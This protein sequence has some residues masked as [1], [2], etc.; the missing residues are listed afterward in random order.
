MKDEMFKFL[1]PAV[2]VD[3]VLFTIKDNDLKVAL[4]KRDDEPYF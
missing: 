1:K 3:V 2:A 4:V